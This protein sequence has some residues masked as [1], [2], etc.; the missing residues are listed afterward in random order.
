MRV[1][2]KS[3]RGQGHSTRDDAMTFPGYAGVYKILC[4]S[5]RTLG[6]LLIIHSS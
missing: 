3:D 5:G 6:C 2:A 1:E 4:C